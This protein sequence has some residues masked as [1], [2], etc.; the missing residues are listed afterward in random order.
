[1]ACANSYMLK[2]LLILSLFLL[3]WW[4]YEYSPCLHFLVCLYFLAFKNN[5]YVILC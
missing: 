3:S 4:E 2:S 1:M 5:V